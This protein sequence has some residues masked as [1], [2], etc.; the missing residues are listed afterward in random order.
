MER[1]TRVQAMTAARLL[2]G[3]TVAPLAPANADDLISFYAGSAVGQAGVA[4]DA[5][6]FQVGD[7]RANHS[8]YKLMAGIRPIS[9]FG[10]EM[11]YFDFGYPGGSLGNAA[12]G[13]NPGLVTLGLTLRFF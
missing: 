6:N 8:A 11:S 5:E 4:A 9:P 3:A 12:A 13:A 10:V 7:F 2:V 1:S